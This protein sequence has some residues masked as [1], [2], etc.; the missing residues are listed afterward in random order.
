MLTFAKLN[1]SVFTGPICRQQ[2]IAALV[3]NMILLINGVHIKRSL[4]TATFRRANSEI[5][6]TMICDRLIEQDG[7]R[8]Q[9][10]SKYWEF[11]GW[12]WVKQMLL[13]YPLLVYQTKVGAL[14][15]FLCFMN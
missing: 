1:A 5:P 7:S 2:L 11:I 3:N 14:A 8:N 13:L 10:S 15:S 4:I 12:K 6:I 9:E